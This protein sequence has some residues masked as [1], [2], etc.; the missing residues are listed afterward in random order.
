MILHI[1]TL[2]L[3]ANDRIGHVVIK[4][5]ADKVVL[6]YTAENKDTLESVLEP[7]KKAKIPVELMLVS[8][9][10]YN[11]ILVAMLE[12]IAAHEKYTIEFN[13]SCGTRAMTAAVYA[14]AMITD[15]PVYLVPDSKELLDELIEV[16]PVSV[17]VLTP[18]KRHIL[19]RLERLGG[20][21]KSNKELG[22]RISLNA[23]SV[24]K[25]LSALARAGYVEQYRENGCLKTTITA[26][27]RAVLKIK[28]IGRQRKWER[29]SKLGFQSDT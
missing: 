15:S 14:A 9:W 16:R 17:A 3:H 12:V 27:G 5:G 18:Q 10:S 23:T 21:I 22:T 26:L 2:G 11:D 1:A 28:Q 4:R 6:L 13:G 25:H 7:F 29:Q 24:S 19:E 20:S 8:A